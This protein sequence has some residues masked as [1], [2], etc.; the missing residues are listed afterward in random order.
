MST[1]NT[2][3]RRKAPAVGRFLNITVVALYRWSGG[4]IGGKMGQARVLLLTTTGRRSGQPHTIPINYF[5]ADNGNVF[6]VASNGGR[7][8]NPAWYFNLTANP[9]AEIQIGRERAA[10]N[11]TVAPPDERARLWQRLVAVMPLYQRYALKA[12]RE[13]PIVVLHKV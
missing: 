12:S 6:V 3:A 11:A 9:R 2:P 8:T 10:V 4:A 13:I 7:E 5:D 1:A